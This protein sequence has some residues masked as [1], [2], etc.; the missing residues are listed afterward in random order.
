MSVFGQPTP[1]FVQR[2]R[3]IAAEQ[4]H[5]D[6]WLERLQG[7]KGSI[8]SDG[9]ERLSTTAAFDALGVSPHER[10]PAAGKRLKSLMEDLGWSAIRQI[11]LTPSGTPAR[12]RGYARKR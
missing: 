3:M 11:H 7:L 5:T 10:T 8:G 1:S 4:A 6:P 2:L 9:V 12:M